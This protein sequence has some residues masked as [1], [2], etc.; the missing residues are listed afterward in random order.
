M[1]TLF[2]HL[3]SM[4]PAPSSREAMDVYRHAFNAR[5]ADGS[6]RP[7]VFPY[8]LYG[9]FFLVFYLCIPHTQNPYIY[10]A[11]WPVLAVICWWQWK[12]LQDATSISMATGFAVGLTSAWGAVWAFTWL[13]WN[14]PQWDA[15]RVQR[16]MKV[17]EKG[18]PEHNREANGSAGARVGNGSTA[19]LPDR[20]GDL[21]KRIPANRHANVEQ[22]GGHI[23][24][25]GD[26]Q[27]QDSRSSE[28]S[29]GK[30]EGVEYYW[31]PYP[32]NL[33]ERFPWIIDLLM[34]FRMP[35][36]NLAIPPLPAP[37]PHIKTALGEPIDAAS[38]S[39]VS[40]IGLRRFNS[41]RELFNSRVPRFIIG[42]FL[43]DIMK[44]I[45]KKDPYFTF[46]PNTYTLPPHLQGFS[47]R[48]LQFIRQTIS[49]ISIIVSAE[50]VFFL[51]PLIICLLLG[52]SIIG[53]RGEAWYYPTTWGS[54]SSI[55][56]KGLNGL[57]GSWWHQ[58][59]R[60]VFSAPTNYFIRNKY[61]SPKS[62]TAKIS[63]LVFAFGI[64][65]FLHAG[66]S[67]NQFPRH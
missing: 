31:Q 44:I 53:L 49:S 26:T 51:A 34:N 20:D 14:R 4:G 17:S 39:G 23:M 65:G 16:R 12:T 64:S 2:P 66:G 33:R 27:G 28:L 29:L 21:R 30:E 45:M 50:M 8:H 7:L 9:M 47:P 46:G 43:L 3:S 36:W 18:T 63:A 10:A 52:P 60:F 38:K 22:S 25:N 19:S 35:G 58:T 15:K 61:F 59:F 24:A 48:T 54:F 1:A 62:M 55:L 41:R 57:W 6:L 67:I 42:Y 40:S 32:S 11:R 5:V 37:P 56:T 13:V